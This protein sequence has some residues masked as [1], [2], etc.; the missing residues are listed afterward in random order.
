[1]KIKMKLLSDV[2]FGNGM[3]IPGGEDISVLRD[4]YGFPY[5]KGGTFKGVLREELE[6][7]LELKGES[8]SQTIIKELLGESGD[9]EIESDSKLVFSDFTL[10]DAVK[11]VMVKEL[12][13]DNPERVLNDLTHVR[14][15]TALS[16]DGT[17]QHGSLR[18][19]RCVNKGLVFYGSINNTDDKYNELI[20]ETLGMIKWIGSMRNRGFGR[21]ELAVEEA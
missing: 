4:E 20:K 14:T 2:I 8:N 7:L 13:K 17:V 6:R 3:S 15:F 12:G 11:G 16:D 10:S 18:V 19:A 5:Y 21:I 1:M 9:S